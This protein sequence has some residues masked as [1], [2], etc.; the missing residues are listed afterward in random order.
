ME[1]IKNYRILKARQL[2]REG[3]RVGEVS[4]AVGF[5]NT[6]HFIRTFTAASGLSPKRYAQQY[7]SI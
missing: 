2:L 4:E 6:E 1:Y 5:R 3:A 7:K